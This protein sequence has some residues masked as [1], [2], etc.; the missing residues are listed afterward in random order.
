MKI[1]L[2]SSIF[3]A[4]TNTHKKRKGDKEPYTLVHQKKNLHRLIQK[5]KE[6]KKEKKQICYNKE[7]KLFGVPG[8]V[9][10]CCN[11]MPKWHAGD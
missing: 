11:A 7:K 9:K 2:I 3:T 6:K 10:K 8:M 1:F 5:E 4:G